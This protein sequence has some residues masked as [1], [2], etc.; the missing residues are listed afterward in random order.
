MN[1]VWLVADLTGRPTP[2]GVTVPLA[3]VG[4]GLIAAA[5]RQAQDVRRLRIGGR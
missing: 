2:L 5:A 1:T 4:A 3:V